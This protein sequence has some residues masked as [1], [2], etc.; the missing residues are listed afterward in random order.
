I[1]II[2][3]KK[4]M[5]N[6]TSETFKPKAIDF[7]SSSILLE[8]IIISEVDSFPID[9]YNRNNNGRIIAISINTTNILLRNL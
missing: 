9:K 6:E 1:T 3:K 7:A 5:M 8:F 2:E 4:L